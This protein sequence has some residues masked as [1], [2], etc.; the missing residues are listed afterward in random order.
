MKWLLLILLPLVV[1]SGAAEDEADPRLWQHPESITYESLR[2]WHRAGGL[3][4]YIWPK[5]HRLALTDDKTREQVFLGLSGFGRGM[6][7]ALFTP[8]K[9][10]G[11]QMLSDT[12]E[13]SQQD[14]EVLPPK[15]GRWHDFL[16]TLPSGRGG[17][18][19]IVYTWNGRRYVQKSF[20]EIS[21]D[22]LVPH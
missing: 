11:W 4:D 2:A 7:Y 1:S 16:A 19:H 8:K 13:G 18:F 21:A 20:H 22:D 9:E 17:E 15:H 5:E 12:I 10:S 3:Q 14:F 6:V